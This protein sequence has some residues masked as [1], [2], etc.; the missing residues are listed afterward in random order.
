MYPRDALLQAL[1]W[2]D[3]L[4]KCAVAV[5]ENLTDYDIEMPRSYQ[6][7]YISKEEVEQLLS[8]TP[9]T[10]TLQIQVELE[11]IWFSSDNHTCVMNEF[12]LTCRMI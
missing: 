7:L 1:Q 8:R 3:S 10:P 5:V 6:G 11:D 9:G 2:L 12:S 4:L